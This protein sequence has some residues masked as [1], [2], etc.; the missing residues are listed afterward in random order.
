M[1]YSAGQ[2]I[3]PGDYNGFINDNTNYFNHI[4]SSG[5]GNWGYGQTAL[6]TV[7]TGDTVR[8]TE[9]YKLVKGIADVASHQGTSITALGTV[10]TNDLIQIINA[11]ESDIQTIGSSR[12]NASSVGSTSTSSGAAGAWSNYCTFTATVNFASADAARYF[13]NAGGM[14]RMAWSRSGGT[15]NPR[16]VEWTDLLSKAGTIVQTQ[17]GGTQTIAGTSYTGITK[18]GGG[19]SAA[20]LATGSGYYGLTPGAAATTVFTQYADTAPYTSSYI[21]VTAALNA[22]SSVLT[23]VTTLVDSGGYSPTDPTDGTLVQTMVVR[24]PE[25]TYLTNTWGTPAMSA[26]SWVLT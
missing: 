9:W 17:G 3:V 7:A 26:A 18:I 11:I 6:P 14:I 24:P 16:D 25:T 19:G 13:F 21:T 23:F 1:T 4:F 22:G 8:A 12:L 2:I 5:S 20:V 10:A 15:G